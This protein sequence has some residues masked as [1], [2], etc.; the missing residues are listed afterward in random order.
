MNHLV[1]VVMAEVAGKV[2]ET[3][4]NNIITPWVKGKNTFSEFGDVILSTCTGN[5]IAVPLEHPSKRGVL[6][7][8]VGEVAVVQICPLPKLNQ[9]FFFRTDFLEHLISAIGRTVIH[10]D[11][12]VGDSLDGFDGGSNPVGFVFHAH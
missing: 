11:N 7:S 4:I 12:F 5:H 10:D 3:E 9:P 6:Q 8:E 1:R 2:N